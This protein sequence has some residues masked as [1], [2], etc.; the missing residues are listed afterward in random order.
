MELEDRVVHVTLAG[1]NDAKA[2]VRL[3]IVRVAREK[4]QIDRFGFIEAPLAV[5]EVAEKARRIGPFWMRR[6]KTLECFH[7]S[8]ELARGN[9]L[10][11]IKDRGPLVHCGVGV[12]RKKFRVLRP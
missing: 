3:F 4:P 10:A 7:R 2:V 5:I 8:I 9:Q 6:D 12:D 1:I 11:R